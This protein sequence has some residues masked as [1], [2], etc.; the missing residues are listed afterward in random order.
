[1]EKTAEVLAQMK[2]AVR[3]QSNWDISTS[4]FAIRM[5]AQRK[6]EQAEKIQE[7]Q[8]EIVPEKKEENFEIVPEKE[9]VQEKEILVEEIK[10]VVPPG[11]KDYIEK[12]KAAERQLEENERKMK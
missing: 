4:E 7:E 9:I 2:H 11:M 6:K 12:Q 3:P 8:K 5:E 1:M 10:P